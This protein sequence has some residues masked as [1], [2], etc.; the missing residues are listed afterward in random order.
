MYNSFNGKTTEIIRKRLN[1]ALIDKSDTH[2]K[3]KLKGHR[4]PKQSKLSFE[5]KNADYEKF[6]LY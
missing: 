3:T 1:L 4:K 6:N 2:W 5:D